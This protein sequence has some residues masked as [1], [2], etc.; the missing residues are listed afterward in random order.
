MVFVDIILDF[1]GPCLSR[2]YLF[3]KQRSSSAR[4]ILPFQIL[5]SQTK[6]IDLRDNIGPPSL[7]DHALAQESFSYHVKAAFLS[8]HLR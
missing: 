5:T 7:R 1:V 6:S 4:Q 3:N 2:S 8:S